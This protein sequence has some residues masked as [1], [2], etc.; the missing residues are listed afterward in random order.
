[1]GIYL[2]I[3]LASFTE[4]TYLVLRSEEELCLLIYYTIPSWHSPSTVRH[5]DSWKFTLSDKFCTVFSMISEI[6][7]IARWNTW[8]VNTS[9]LRSSGQC[10]PILLKGAGH[11]RI[12]YKCDFFSLW[13]LGHNL[14]DDHELVIGFT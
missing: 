2:F 3:Y 6:L 7:N 14:S 13:I 9:S 1:M 4:K 5:T 10:L 8:S 12:Q 11:G